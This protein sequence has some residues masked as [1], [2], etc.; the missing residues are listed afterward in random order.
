MIN[1]WKEFSSWLKK[2]PK[3]DLGIY[4]YLIAINLVGIWMISGSF[5]A[6]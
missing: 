1:L 3:W 2:K 5:Q 6:L 4:L